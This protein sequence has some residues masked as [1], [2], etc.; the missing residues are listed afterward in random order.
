MNLKHSCLCYDSGLD[1]Y[2]L[3]LCCDFSWDLPVHCFLALAPPP[4]L[5]GVAYDARVAQ[6]Q[7][8]IRQDI[9]L[10]LFCSIIMFKTLINL[11]LTSKMFKMVSKFECVR[12]AI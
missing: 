10:D 3:L 9:L 6:N 1:R 8:Q 2:R 4:V 5:F 11:M 12:V 7:A